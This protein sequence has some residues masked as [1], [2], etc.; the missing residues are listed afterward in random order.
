[1]ITEEFRA[2]INLMTPRQ[3]TDRIREEI[4]DRKELMKQMGG[5]LYPSILQGEIEM[6]RELF[7]EKAK[8]I[9]GGTLDASG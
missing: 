5:S 7:S 2:A 1:M 3:A 8:G 4:R 9:T 6:L